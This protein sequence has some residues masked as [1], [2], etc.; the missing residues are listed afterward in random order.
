MEAMPSGSGGAAV[1]PSIAAPLIFS[2]EFVET[3]RRPI[4]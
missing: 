4:R 1:S 2:A 3:K